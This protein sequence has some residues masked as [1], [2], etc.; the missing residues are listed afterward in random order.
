MELSIAVQC[1]LKDFINNAFQKFKQTTADNVDL[2]NPSCDTHFRERG[3]YLTAKIKHLLVCVDREKGLAEFYDHHLHSWHASPVLLNLP[4]NQSDFHLALLGTDQSMLY[5]FGGW[6]TRGR[7]TKRLWRRNLSDLDSSQWTAKAHMNYSR[8]AFA[9][10]FINDN[11]YVLGGKHIKNDSFYD[12][13]IRICELYYRSFNHWTTVEPM[14]SCRVNASAAVLNGCIY[15]AG[16]WTGEEVE[17]S[18]EKYDLKSLCQRWILVAPMNT[19]RYHFVLTP[20]DGRLWAIGGKSKEGDDIQPLRSCES[21]DL[22]TDTWREEAPMKEGR[23]GHAAI[24]F[25]GELYVVGGE[26]IGK[27]NKKMFKI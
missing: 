25:N 19:A 22:V 21:Y 5:A 14:N 23:D 27:L 3:I 1:G 2:L 18:V 9:S 7:P 6:N 13:P 11:I 12:C 15:I 4:N 20:F 10:V 8:S 26:K 24:E 16:G 17:K